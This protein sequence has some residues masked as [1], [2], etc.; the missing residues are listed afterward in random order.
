M[1]YI[2][3][4]DR[5]DVINRSKIY[6][7]N[8]YQNE[9]LNDEFVKT[10]IQDVD[11]S[12]VISPH[13]IESSVLGSIGPKNL[14]GGVKTLILMYKDSEHIFNATNCGDNCAKWI[15][16]ISRR[17]DLTIC[18]QH[19]MDFRFGDFEAVMLNDNRKI[20]NMRD[21]LDAIFELENS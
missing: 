11:R 2:Y 19:I 4:G 7:N 21:L 8:T 13:L 20:H 9:W 10:M 1:L 5:D 6:F 12:E 17:K 16:E 15:L 14:S 3:Y 18:L